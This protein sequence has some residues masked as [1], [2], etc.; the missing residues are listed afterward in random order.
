MEKDRGQKP[1]NRR[2]RKGR[3]GGEERKNNGA[4]TDV[5]LLLKTLELGQRP[6]TTAATTVPLHRLRSLEPRPTKPSARAEASR[7][8]ADTNVGRT[9]R[10]RKECS[11]KGQRR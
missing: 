1:K 9:K 2:E 3:G 7:A 10:E 4:E 6:R 8:E 5:T 11:F